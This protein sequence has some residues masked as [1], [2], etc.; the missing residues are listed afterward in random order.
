MEFEHRSVPLDRIDDADTTYRIS[1]GSSTQAIEASIRQIGLI[2]PPILLPGREY[3][4]IISGFA[5]IS[6][7]RRLGWHRIAARCLSAEVPYLRRVLLAIADNAGQRELNVVELARSIGLIAGQ[8]ADHDQQTILLCSLGLQVNRDLVQK[9]GQILQMTD[10]LQSGLAEGTIALPVALRLHAMRDRESA[11]E[12]AKLFQEL[13]L[14]LNRQRELLD[15]TQGIEMREGL[16]TVQ[17]LNQDPIAAWRRDETKDRGHVSQLIR[18]YLKN[19]RYPEIT[20]FE[21]HYAKCLQE[22]KLPKN[23]RIEAPPHFEGRTFCLRYDFQNQRDLSDLNRE[24]Q[25]I[26][27][28]PALSEILSPTGTGAA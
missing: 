12:L 27:G 15:W 13:R 16:C 26:I 18:Q 1:F 9:L 17:I 28:S 19:R 25:R 14:G 20:A 24:L 7:C 4:I 8:A 21:R 22:L 23:L 10:R 2:N 11:E 3:H 6:A 5:R